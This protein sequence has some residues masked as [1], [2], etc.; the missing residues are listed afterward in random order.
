VQ[1]QGTSRVETQGNLDTTGKPFDLALDG[2]GFFQIEVPP[3]GQIAFTR[4][5]NFTLSP[6]GQLITSQGFAVTPPVQIPLD[7]E[8]ITVGQDGVITAVTAA[9][10]QPVQVG[11]LVLASFVNPAGLRAIG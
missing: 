1:V 11:E 6:E 3:N 7:A 2:P 5:G 8:S 4:A 10:P 9:A